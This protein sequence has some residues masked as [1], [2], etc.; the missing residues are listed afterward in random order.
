MTRHTQS[1]LQDFPIP[2]TRF[3]SIHID[4]IGKLPVS[5]GFS[6]A[7]TCI[8]RFTWWLEVI[9]I[10]DAKTQSV[11]SALWY[12]WI[13]R[14]GVPSRITTDRGSQ[15]ARS[16]EFKKTYHQQANGMIERPHRQ[17]KEA[18]KLLEVGWIIFR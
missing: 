7:L 5:K 6:F 17:L 18:L 9:L 14:F 16:S 15:F 8:C 12:G 3:S 2:D 4:L 1:P 13:S 11:L 10:V